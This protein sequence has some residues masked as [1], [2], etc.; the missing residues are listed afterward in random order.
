MGSGPTLTAGGLGGVD[1][2]AAEATG[3]PG[4]IG[5][6]SNAGSAGGG[7][8]VDLDTGNGAAGGARGPGDSGTGLGQ[9]LGL[10]GATGSTGQTFASAAVIATN[11][12]GGTG[13][14]GANP[15]NNVSTSGAGGGGGVGVSALADVTVTGGVTVRGGAGRAQANAGSGGG[16]AGIFSIAQVNVETG[17]TV[18]GGAG[19]GATVTGGAG[20]GA[21]GVLLKAGAGLVNAGA[22]VGGAGGAGSA[23]TANGGGGGGA[24][25]QLTHGGTVV[26]LAG[27]SIA[28]GVGGA[29]RVIGG[30]TGAGGAGVKGVDVTVINAGTI[31]GALSGAWSGA[32][33]PA[34]VQAAAVAFIGGVNTLELQAGSVLNGNAVAFSRADT[35]RLGGDNDA[36]FNVADLGAAGSAASYQGF[37]VFEK[38]GASTWTLT[39]ATAETTNW[40]IRDGAL[41][42]ASDASLGAS[43]G[44]VT[45]NGGALRTTTVIGTARDI[46]LGLGGGTLQTDADLE[47]TGA[48]GGVGKL[49]K[50][51][52]GT[53]TLVGAN[54]YSG[55]TDIAGGTVVASIAS[56]GTGDIRNDG[57]L[58]LA[59]DANAV[60]G[61]IIDGIGTLTK[62]GSGRV[63]L[64]GGGAMSGGTRVQAGALII[65]GAFANSAVTVASGATLGGSG[66][67]GA[68]TVQ[69]GG[70]IAPGNSIGT[71]RVNGNY[72]QQAGST[73]VVEIG[74]ASADQI[75]VN[76]T[77]TLDAGA[78]MSVVRTGSQLYK[79]GTSYQVL[80]TTGGLTGTY[81]VSGDM[82]VTP[83]LSLAER[84][85]ATNAYLTVTQTGDVE[86][87]A[88]TPNQSATAGGATGTVVSD[89]LLNS[90]TFD[91]ARSALDQLS[92]SALASAKGAML[93]DS[94]YS[95]DLAIDRLRNAFCTEGASEPHERDG[96]T[97]GD[98]CGNGR[99]AWGQTWG[100]WGHTN[101][102]GNAGGI[103]RDS[104]GFV[105]GVD[106]PTGAWRVGVLAG[107]SSGR[108][109]VDDQNARSSTDDYHLGVYGGTQWDRLALRLGGVYTWHDIDSARDVNVAAVGGR[110]KA[111]Y[112]ANTA[113]AF[114]EL[115][116]RL[117]DG[118]VTMEPFV[119]LAYVNLHTDGFT[120]SGGLAALRSRGGDTS[121]TF[122]TLGLRGSS[123]IGAGSV[124][125][126]VRG[127][128]GWRRAYGDITP[129]SH[130]SFQGGDVFTIS[131]VPLGKDAV[132][133]GAGLDLH[134]TSRVTASVAFDGQFGGGATDRAVS[135]SLRVL[136]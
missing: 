33:A 22:I 121:T 64:N 96:R 69:T 86:D 42:I 135:A 44:K 19:G 34:R 15:Q 7:G 36:G 20:G 114:A 79:A 85:D 52:A 101:G 77:A 60:D 111:D 6:G 105:V 26:N 106:V 62:Q 67:V 124:D 24:G 127:L 131:G 84:Y 48:I 41:S 118:P 43:D 104:A 32:G 93:Y 37:G 54:T 94:R 125:A 59:Q 89:A 102:N 25:V 2:T 95:R 115:G 3:R 57:A 29:G 120:E 4:S 123:R 81:A 70:A 53:L 17:A 76:G 100:G 8:A 113:Q 112:R 5:S 99:V 16:G 119:N 80:G 68:T 117:G 78:A 61:R 82:V 28:G 132:V 27:G 136:F 18:I 23:V 90:P 65:N 35:L 130:V 110:M 109:K 38:R 97:N 133:I 129:Q 74:G 9:A 88:E 12:T 13:A 103:D 128:V 91:A 98:T 50:T 108:Y 47:S 126:T 63:V 10:A 72:V 1:G 58:V 83:F 73:Y 45:L 46:E 116:Y 31:T 71:L 66:S 92:G 87:A 14:A 56:L 51:G 55:G 11:V 122:S 30:Q 107:Y 49:T 40:T 21:M 39:G 134:V 75:A